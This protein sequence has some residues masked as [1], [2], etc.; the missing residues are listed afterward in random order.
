MLALAVSSLAFS[1]PLRP[2]APART[3]QLTML[4]GPSRND[5]AKI[6][7]ALLALL[8]VVGPVDEAQ[9]ARMGG[10]MGGRAPSM[11]RMSGGMSGGM[12]GGYGGGMRGGTN[13]Y[14]SP[15]MGMGMGMGYGYGMSPF[16]FGISPGAYL[17]L[18]LAEAFVREQQRQAFLEQQLR[19]AQELGQDQAMIAQL[20]SQLN[21]QNGKVEAIRA[22]QAAEGGDAPATAPAQAPSTE[23]E[24][25]QLLQKQLQEQ[26]AEIA[27]LKAAQ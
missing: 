3:G 14:V 12:R 2:A 21:E 10:R 7:S 6:G 23:S 24:A 9:A 25:I 26:Q 22:R 19:T 16:G 27:A 17:G 18:S 15:G 11:G 1:A 4:T 20:Q 8:L 5:A 13:V